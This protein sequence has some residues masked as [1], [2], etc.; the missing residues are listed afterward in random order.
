MDAYIIIVSEDDKFIW[1][2][3]QCQPET[4][5]YKPHPVHK[6][7]FEEVKKQTCRCSVGPRRLYSKGDY[8]WFDDNSTYGGP[9]WHTTRLP[10]E[11]QIFTKVELKDKRERLRNVPHTVYQLELGKEIP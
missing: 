10:S 7:A 6:G 4:V 8:I 9:M 5:G 1:P 2:K 3:C 11:A